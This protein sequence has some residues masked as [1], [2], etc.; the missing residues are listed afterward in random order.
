MADLFV[1]YKAEDRP[2]VV[3]LVAA[4]K[5]DGVDLW[6]DAEIGGGASWR[7]AIETELAAARCVL[8]VWSRRSTGPQGSFVRDE[9][10]RALRRGIYLPVRIDSVEPPLGFGETQALSLLRW[11]GER[12]DPD[13]QAVLATARATIAGAARPRAGTRSGPLTGGIDRRVLIGG[14]AALA[15]AAGLAGWR[16]LR[17]VGGGA[18]TADSVAVL[19]F[20]NLSGDPAQAYFSDGIA[21]ELRSA[22]SRLVRL[23]VAARASSEL[24]RAADI[25]TAAAKLGVANIVTGSVRR[26]GGT[27]RVGAQL[28]DSSSGLVRW[29]ETYDRAAGDVLSIETGIAESV[30]GALDI[31]LG[32]G[33]KALLAAGSTSNPVARDAYLRGLAFEAGQKPYAALPEY[34]AAV[35][36]DPKYALALAGHASITCWLAVQFTDHPERALAQAAAE[37]RRAVALA[38]ELG[39]PHCVLGFILYMQLDFRGAEAAFAKAYRLAPGD[40]FILGRYSIYL[41]AVGRGDEAVGLVE[42]AQQL[43]PLRPNGPLLL[44]WAYYAAGRYADAVAALRLAVA[45]LPDD[46]EGRSKLAMALIAANQPAE[47]LRVASTITP[48]VG[49]REVAEGIARDKLG[50]RAGSD[51]VVDQL[52]TTGNSSY[53]IAMIH[54]QRGEV[55]AAFAALDHAVAIREGGICELKGDPMMRPLRGDPRFAALIRRIG[56]P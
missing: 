11:K 1:S 43:D 30:A 41:N 56:F 34:A 45:R 35:A 2:R 54:A 36:A 40:S 23:K 39:L 31:V 22:L 38:P 14:G 15:A 53:E 16:A 3:P 29:S 28:V 10:T 50:D 12:A 6:W 13:Y 27:I 33:E 19:P 37:A 25:P 4:L 7:E 21:E 46:I 5:A 55:E 18:A 47:A 32:R 42:R 26:G 44:G 49:F 52:R 17:G 24:M 51:R 8:V 20:A 9:A 48:G